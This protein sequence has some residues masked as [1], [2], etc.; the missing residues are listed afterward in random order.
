MNK[1]I[2]ILLTLLSF[3][4]SSCGNKKGP[5][6]Y[7][8]MENGAAEKPVYAED[9]FSDPASKQLAKA[10]VKSDYDQIKE[11]SKDKVLLNKQ[12]EH[13]VTHLWIAVS[14]QDM[15]SVKMLLENGADP[16]LKMTWVKPPLITALFNEGSPRKKVD[17]IFRLLLDHGADPNVKSVSQDTKVPAIFYANYSREK[18]EMLL[19]KGADIDA[20]D[21]EGMT[22]LLANAGPSKARHAIHYLELGANL[23]ARGIEGRTMVDQLEMFIKINKDNQKE[24]EPIFKWLK[25]HGY[26]L[27]D[28]RGENIEGE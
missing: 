12:G 8:D 26:K 13:G 10:I 18:I 25:D 5:V 16:N 14:R 3:L 28:L 6:L 24:F 2:I 22:A 15:K 4:S 11:M 1:P 21:Q 7:Y 23:K 17:G 27:S 9:I 19:K 20:L